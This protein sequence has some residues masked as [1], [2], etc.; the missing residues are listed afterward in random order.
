MSNPWYFDYLQI[1]PTSDQ[2]QIKKAYARL[3]KTFDPEQDPKR[4]EQLREAYEYAL[5]WTTDTPLADPTTVL[6]IDL[7]DFK[8]SASPDR[9]QLI[10]DTTA[11]TETLTPPQPASFVLP[12]LS[13]SL[14]RDIHHTLR[15]CPEQL[16]TRIDI[17]IN[18]LSFQQREL[19]EFFLQRL[20]S[21]SDMPNRL[22][23]YEV[24]LKK[25]DW[26][27][28]RLK[29]SS[30]AH[31]Q[32]LTYQQEQFLALSAHQQLVFNNLIHRLNAFEHADFLP[33]GMPMYDLYEFHR[34]FPDWLKLHLNTQR[35]TQIEQ[36][37]AKAHYTPPVKDNSHRLFMGIGFFILLKIIFL[38]AHC[39]SN[40]SSTSFA[41]S[42]TFRVENVEPETVLLSPQDCPAFRDFDSERSLLINSRALNFIKQTQNDGFKHSFG[43]KS[44]PIIISCL[45]VENL[46]HELHF[47]PKAH[48]RQ[49]IQPYL[50]EC[51]T[52]SRPTLIA[53]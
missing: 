3:L 49:I 53:P 41:G 52:K 27:L 18:N 28:I 50:D 24:C 48:V 36:A 43:G 5:A 16:G 26:S 33:S 29:D 12:L 14:I 31:W 37:L 47:E 45:D 30:L 6:S 51:L 25:F 8:P 1:E 17:S 4:F 35:I 39:Q 22:A 7:E 21:R 23:L 11:S 10:T 2:R 46:V 19:F 42:T 32:R 44:L 40:H 13:P 9:D 34:Q 38:L 15:E 20:L